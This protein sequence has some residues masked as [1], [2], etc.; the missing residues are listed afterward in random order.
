VKK[1]FW[2]WGGILLGGVGLGVWFSLSNPKAVERATGSPT[3]PSQ[4]VSAGNGKY[5]PEETKLNVPAEEEELSIHPP[6]PDLQAELQVLRQQLKQKPDR[7]TVLRRLREF[8]ARMLAANPDRAAA[9][10]LQFLQ[11]GEDEATG[12]EFAVGE[13]GLE[14]WPSLRAFLL[15]LLGKIDPEMASRYA[16]EA[17]IPAKN[18][19]V[20]YA[21]SLQI[22]WNHGGAEKP[23]PELTSAWLGLLQ[24]PDWAAQ[25]DAAWLESLDFAGRIPEVV[26]ESLKVFGWWLGKPEILPARVAAVDLALERMAVQ[27][28]GV[29]MEVLMQDTSLLDRGRGPYQRAQI[30]SRANLL[31]ARQ[32]R[33][34]EAY[35]DKLEPRGREVAWFFAAFPC[36]NFSVSPGLTGQPKLGTAAEILPADQ[37]ALAW[38]ARQ[39]NASWA[40]QNPDLWAQGVEKLKRIVEEQ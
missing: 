23:T 4:P 3:G 11:S 13:A 20:E 35:L 5:V 21:V 14:E 18:S 37:A 22:L 27:Q 25:P 32:V 40:R 29:T 24:K 6:D 15:D 12:L 34:L 26:P 9:T 10:L 33:L 8:M 39:R 2:R 36:H 1:D 38:L 30:F 28:P 19:T 31:D 7:E 16:L 17:V